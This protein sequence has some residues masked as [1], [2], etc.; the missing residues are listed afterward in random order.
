MDGLYAAIINAPIATIFI[1]A[2]IIFLGIAVLGKIS[3]KIEPGKS[4]RIASGIFGIILLGL[5]FA[6]Y[7]GAIVPSTQVSATQTALSPT[8]PPTTPPLVLASSVTAVPVENINVE[9]TITP[10]VSRIYNFSAC[11]ERCTGANATRV[12]SEA[13]KKLYVQWE[14]ENIPIGA[15]YARVWS[16]DGKEWVRYQCTWPGPNSGTDF[17][18]LREPGGLR[19]GDWEVTILVNGTVLLREQIQVQ[20]N[21]TYWDPAGTRYSCY[22]K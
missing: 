13:T 9:P 2:G 21:W 17:V 19:S 22:D 10:Y 16:M 15:D 20:G 18:T 5:G 8:L 11:P 7:L 14:F 1:I 3:G 4:G 12:F 6:M